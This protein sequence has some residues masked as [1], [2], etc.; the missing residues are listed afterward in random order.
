MIHDSQTGT[1]TSRQRPARL[2]DGRH[3]EV[4]A[5]T[6]EGS[7]LKERREPGVPEREITLCARH[8]L[9]DQWTV[10]IDCTADC[11]LASE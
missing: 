4:S 7:G 6:S 2:R 1:I 8:V 10:L 3:R 11:A 9:N 5:P